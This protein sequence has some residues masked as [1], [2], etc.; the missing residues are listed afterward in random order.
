MKYHKLTRVTPDRLLEI[1]LNLGAL[2]KTELGYR[3]AYDDEGRAWT[4]YRVGKELSTMF[5]YKA[6]SRHPPYAVLR[7]LKKT[8]DEYCITWPE[9]S[10]GNPEYLPVASDRIGAIESTYGV[11][12]NK[13]TREERRFLSKKYGHRP[14]GQKGLEFDERMRLCIKCRF[15]HLLKD[16]TSLSD[17]T[18][19]FQPEDMSQVLQSLSPFS[20]SHRYDN[21]EDSKSY[22]E[23]LNEYCQ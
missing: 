6:S 4:K 14:D 22:D 17:Q 23:T 13:A 18:S 19:T 2:K 20:Y 5:K 12:M 11:D 1:L 16:Q 8:S 15:G 10:K 21:H 3:Y 9:Y 7:L